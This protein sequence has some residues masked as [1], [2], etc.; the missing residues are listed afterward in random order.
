MKNITTFILGNSF[1]P[2]R[3][4]LNINNLISTRC[5]LANHKLQKV[6]EQIKHSYVAINTI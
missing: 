1:K 2:N 6:W 5:E 3:L 4:T